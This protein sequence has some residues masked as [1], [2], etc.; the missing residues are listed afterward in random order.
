VSR[1]I[2]IFFSRILLFT[3]ACVYSMSCVRMLLT[4][5]TYLLTFSVERV[6]VYVGECSEVS[7]LN[8]IVYLFF[9]L[10]I[11]SFNRRLSNVFCWI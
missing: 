9:R 8:L 7:C 1:V 6:F 5:T 10:S 11:Y 2:F 3:F 4:K